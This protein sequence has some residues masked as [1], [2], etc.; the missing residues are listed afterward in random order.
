MTS[1]WQTAVAWMAAPGGSAM[2]CC[3][4][5]CWGVVSLVLAQRGLLGCLYRLLTVAAWSLCQNRIIFFL[6]D[7]LPRY[8]MFPPGLRSP[9]FSFLYTRP[10]LRTAAEWRNQSTAFPL[11]VVS[12]CLPPDTHFNGSLREASIHHQSATCL[13]KQQYNRSILVPVMLMPTLDPILTDT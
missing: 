12:H 2:H 4:C 13:K 1:Q 11:C 10:V 3:C 9:S 6:F 7:F 8:Q 5:C